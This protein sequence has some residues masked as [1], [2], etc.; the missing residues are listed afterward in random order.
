MLIDIPGSE[1]KA[2]LNKSF[3]YLLSGNSGTM[4]HSLHSFFLFNVKLLAKLGT[5][6]KLLLLFLNFNFTSERVLGV[7][8]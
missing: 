2:E 7:D 1:K 4:I 3:A 8:L 5:Y 6:R